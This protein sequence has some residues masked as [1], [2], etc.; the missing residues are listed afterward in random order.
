LGVLYDP[1]LGG[2]DLP[3]VLFTL[4]GCHTLGDDSVLTWFGQEGDL[5]VLF[6]GSFRGTSGGVL[7]PF[8]VDIP[9]LGQGFGFFT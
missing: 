6:R 7:D 8:L 3:K 5:G 1:L 4:L 9:Y 2:M